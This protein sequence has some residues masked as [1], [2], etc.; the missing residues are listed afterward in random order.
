MSKIEEREGTEFLKGDKVVALEDLNPSDENDE[1]LYDSWVKKG[2]IGIVT[3]PSSE[4]NNVCIVTFGKERVIFTH[5]MEYELL[6][7]AE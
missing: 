2:S 4:K 1:L 3:E 7:I 5:Y 6:N